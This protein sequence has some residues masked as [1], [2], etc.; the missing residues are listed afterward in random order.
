MSINGLKLSAV[1]KCVSEVSK[2]ATTGDEAINLTFDFNFG[3]KKCTC[4]AT[5]YKQ[6]AIKASKLQP[7][8]KVVLNGAF[9]VDNYIDKKTGQF[10]NTPK[11]RIN[12][13][14]PENDNST[15]VF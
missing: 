6:V 9:Y 1:V 13:F 11:I 3:Q 7:G 4:F 2:I 15:N 8:D 12:S 14:E 5:A 10:Q